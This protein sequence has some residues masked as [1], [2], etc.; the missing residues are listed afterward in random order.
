MH[1]SAVSYLNTRPLIWG[2]LHGPQ[3]G[4]AQLDFDLPSICAQRLASRDVDAGLVPVIEVARQHLTQV[5]SL[6]IACKGPVRSILLLSKAPLREIRT[7]A[8]DH[9]SRTSVM[10]TR[11]ILAEQYGLYPEMVV[12]PPDLAAMLGKADAALIIGDPALRIQPEATGLYWL[13]LGEAWYRLTGLPM[14]FAVWAGYR[15]HPA[16]AAV[17]KQ[18]YAHGRGKID[19]IVAA[20]AAVRAIPADLARH[21]LEAIIHYELDDEYRR[22]M[23]LYIEHA[24]QLEAKQLV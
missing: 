17:L 20:E 3:Q 9:S 6:G 7:L 13:D 5:G 2:L 4:Q 22:G 24:I 18:S 1:L 10:L 12:Q 23:K 19:E 16:L 8:L 14:V 15:Q 21:Y 11:I